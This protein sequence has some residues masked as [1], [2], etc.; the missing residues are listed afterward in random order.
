MK[1]L[2]PLL[3]LPTLLM[4]SLRLDPFQGG[5]A[6]SLQYW[7]GT[8]A[9]GR[10]TLARL[11]LTAAQA[12]AFASLCAMG[13]LLLA[14]LLAL[15][16]RGTQPALSALRAVPA[17][18]W[19]IPLAALIGGLAWPLLGPL[20]ALLLAPHLEAPLRVK[21]EALRQ[22]PAWS[23]GR[24][25]GAPGL[26]RLRTWAPWAAGEAAALFPSAWLGALWTEVT[27]SAL[28]LGPGPQ[29]DSLGRLLVEE[30]PR[31]A[32]GAASAWAAL[33]LVLVLAWSLSFPEPT[34]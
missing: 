1:R 31:L 21:A 14:W 11:L 13:A 34:P 10:D 17:L 3:L 4:P 32:V 7:L 29:A 19:L 9:L 22:S 26:H 12:G 27:L 30:L 6:P 15:T 20:I 5:A 18:L 25:Q 8:D 16:G 23:M 2:W 33:L 24:L 28:G